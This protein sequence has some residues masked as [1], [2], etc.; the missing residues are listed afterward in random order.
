VCGEQALHVLISPY[1][2]R[3]LG[4]GPAAIGS[5]VG[6][7]GFASLLAR[8]PAGV[9]YS[10]A[11]RRRLLLLGGGLSSAAFLLV[12]VIP[13]PA[14]FAALMAVDGF[15]WSVATTTQLAA[16]VA[17]RPGG[18]GVA[19]A[20]GWYSGFTGLGNTAGGALGGVVA[21]RLGF[22][23]SFLTLAGIVALGT[24]AMV[25]AVPRRSAARPDGPPD[26][27]PRVRRHLG[28]AWRSLAVTPLA[29]W[30]GV[31]VMVYINFMNGLVTTFHPVLVLAAG[32][33][34]SEIGVLSSCRSW[35][36]S[37][38]RLGSGPLFAR[39]GGVH[40]TLPLLVLSSTT[41]FLI[42]TVRS[43]FVWQVP[44][45]LGSGLSR[46]LLRVTGSAEAFEAVEDEERQ[47]GMTA[48]LVQGGLD[49]GKV[50]GP[51]VGGVVAQVAG[52]AA[53]FR[54]VPAALLGLYLALFVAARRSAA[55]TV[56]PVTGGAP[57][58][59]VKR[60]IPYNRD[61]V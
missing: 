15:G 14:P 36:S 1:L 6:I 58:S 39:I 4:L 9:A 29:V 45:F 48:A 35:A 22:G 2:S 34:L 44:L 21:D 10:A 42:P 31:L 23:A 24:A 51:L 27:R 17:A 61:N 54:I 7:F 20:M 43:S 30:I 33:S 18:M 19:A 32:L 55:R 25:A 26:R 41:L 52:L 46:G 49:V 37:V 53:V 11:R 13:G 8:L 57:T 5:V 38:V 56:A 59:A 3:E 47:H 16:L 28:E 40:L 60:S 50:A 12:P